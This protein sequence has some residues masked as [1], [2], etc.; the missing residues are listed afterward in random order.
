MCIVLTLFEQSN[1]EPFLATKL[2][3]YMEQQE[4][5]KDIVKEDKLIYGGKEAGELGQVVCTWP[6]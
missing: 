6:C 2:K 1:L 4:Q 5:L 3:S